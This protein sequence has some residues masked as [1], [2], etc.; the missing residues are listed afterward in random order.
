MGWGLDSEFIDQTYELVI[1][2]S[3]QSLPE[4]RVCKGH[5]TSVYYHDPL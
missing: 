2:H 3:E 4:T 1:T 5:S